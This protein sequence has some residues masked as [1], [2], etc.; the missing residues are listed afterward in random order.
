MN[1][2]LI[3]KASSKNEGA[4]AYLYVQQRGNLSNARLQNN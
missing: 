1:L 4:Q 3:S 2:D